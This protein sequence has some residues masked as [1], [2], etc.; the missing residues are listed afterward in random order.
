[1]LFSSRSIYD[2]NPLRPNPNSQKLVSSSCRIYRLS[3]TLT[4]LIAHQTLER[5]KKKNNKKSLD[6]LT[7][8]S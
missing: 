2:P 8:F 3:W 4:P 1:M 5:K 6:I 7:K